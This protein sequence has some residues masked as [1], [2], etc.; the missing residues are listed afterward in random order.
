MPLKPL[1]EQKIVIAFFKTIETNYKNQNYNNK[2]IN[3]EKEVRFT[4]PADY[5]TENRDSK[6]LLKIKYNNDILKVY[7][8]VS[9]KLFT[10]YN[11]R[12][13]LKEDYLVYYNLYYTTIDTYPFF[14]HRLLEISKELEDNHQRL[15]YILM[16]IDESFIFSGN[17]E[18]KLNTISDIHIHL[19]A[20]ID[21]HYRISYLLKDPYKYSE[22]EIGD[23]IPQ[24]HIVEKNLKTYGTYIYVITHILEAALILDYLKYDS[25]NQKYLSKALDILADFQNRTFFSKDCDLDIRNLFDE[26]HSIR[27]SS[28]LKESLIKIEDRLERGLLLAAMNRFDKN[29]KEYDIKLGD[30]ILVLYLL[31]KLGQEKRNSINYIAIRNYF[32]LRSI[33][34]DS[35]YQTHRRSGFGYFSSYSK[36]IIKNSTKGEMK[37]ILLSMLHPEISTNIEYRMSIPDIST[38]LHNF[39]ATFHKAIVDINK[40]HICNNFKYNFKYGL[41]YNLKYNPKYQI[42]I[43]FHYIKKDDS[44]SKKENLY[45]DKNYQNRCIDYLDE[46][47][48]RYEDA[49][50]I[51]EKKSKVL[52]DL[53][54]KNQIRYYVESDEERCKLYNPQSLI[55]YYVDSDEEKI[56]LA[57][58]Y[59]HGIDA[60]S[61]ELDVPPEAF[62]PIYRYF[63]YSVISSGFAISNHECLGTPNHIN[64]QYTFHVGEEFRDIISGLRAIYESIIFL[65]LQDEDRIGHGVAL[66]IDPKIVISDR[67]HITLTKGEYMDNL[68]FLYYIFSMANNP[69]Y[70]LEELK[71]IIEQLGNEI[72]G[73][74][75]DIIGRSFSVDDFIAAWLLRRNC[76]VAVEKLTDILNDKIKIWLNK[77]DCFLDRGINKERNLACYIYEKAWYLKKYIEYIGYERILDT[78]T[79]T[80]F[81]RGYLKASLPDFIYDEDDTNQPLK[82]YMSIRNSQK[83]YVLYWAYNNKFQ[84]IYKKYNEYYDGNV[85]FPLEVYEYLQDYMMEY[86]VAKKDLVIEILP[87][88]NLLISSLRNMEDHPFLRF[89]PPKEITPNKFGIRTKKIKIALGTD[90]P[91]IQGTS[92]MMEYHIVYSIVSKKYGKEVAQKYIEELVEYGNYI[93]EKG[94]KM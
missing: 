80:T 53:L 10:N 45:S 87:T 72:Y 82:R 16:H 28:Y 77:N 1:I 55:K 17:L 78:T 37:D 46:T 26:L 52:Y 8:G 59:F 19:G 91:G 7:K 6:N 43:I 74:V 85:I 21:F 35:I 15:N 38:D 5:D 88:S 62:A 48:I 69:P 14:A 31:K 18:E 33:I 65:H 32:A 75:S 50:K 20:S 90:D 58:L 11:G 66:G 39:L 29:S 67:E 3:L 60:A 36:N 92:L 56:D 42:K 84:C 47:S 76:P 94:K 70:S 81:D 54:T 63:K 68:V 57:Y 64:L 61:S 49:R 4:Y 83:A 86:V 34:K 89:N 22:I 71:S 25:N 73:D 24:D 13:V 2:S 41:K 9:S 30:K 40:N 79:Y 51:Y 93:F 44:K 27:T 12:I 23:N